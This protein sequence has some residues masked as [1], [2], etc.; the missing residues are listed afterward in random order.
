MSKLL[1]SILLCFLCFWPLLARSIPTD[2][3]NLGFTEN[4]LI[5]YNQQD[6]KEFFTFFDQRTENAEDIVIFIIEEDGKITEV[7]NQDFIKINYTNQFERSASEIEKAVSNFK[8]ELLKE[9][10][11]A[12]YSDLKND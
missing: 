1:I 8:K 4:N 7:N 3:I 9:V 10:E 11:P 6:N 2:L 5:S 12:S